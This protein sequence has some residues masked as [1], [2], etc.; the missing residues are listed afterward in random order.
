MAA[1]HP[2]VFTLIDRSASVA[3]ARV[4]LAPKALNADLVRTI[5]GFDALLVLTGS[6]ASANLDSLVKS[7]KPISE[8]CASDAAYKFVRGLG[9][10]H[11]DAHVR[12]SEAAA[13]FL[14]A[15]LPATLRA[16]GVD[17]ALA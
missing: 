12:G 17:A 4:R 15:D 6:T 13:R 9:L 10:A 16:Q 1:A 5:Y 14:A 7:I 8:L 3:A 11:M 2:D